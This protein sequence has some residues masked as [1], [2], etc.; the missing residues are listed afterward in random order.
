MPL[1]RAHLRQALTLYTDL[2]MP[3][4]DQVRAD[5]TDLDTDRSGH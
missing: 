5:L 1:A 3:E 4:A 2:G